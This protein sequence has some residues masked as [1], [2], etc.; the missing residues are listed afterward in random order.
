MH[1][2]GV[3]EGSLA[4]SNWGH[5]LALL[6]QLDAA[7]NPGET[8]RRPR[9]SPWHVTAQLCAGGSDPT[10]P[11]LLPIPHRDGDAA[12]QPSQSIRSP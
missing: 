4:S 11:A 9:E 6:T 3:R 12:H 10:I 5:A 8:T 1:H 7:G 2:V